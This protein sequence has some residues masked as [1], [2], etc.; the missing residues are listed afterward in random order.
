MADKH[1]DLRDTD[2]AAW[3]ASTILLAFLA[4]HPEIK[5]AADAFTGGSSKASVQ[6]TIGGKKLVAIITAIEAF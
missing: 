2:P 3:L 4:A 5:D 6:V 1:G